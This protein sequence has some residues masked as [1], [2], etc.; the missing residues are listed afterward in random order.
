MLLYADDST[1]IYT[2]NAKRAVMAKNINEAV[3]II[4]YIAERLGLIFELIKQ[5]YFVVAYAGKMGGRMKPKEHADL[6]LDLKIGDAVLTKEYT[7][8]TYLGL[9]IDAHLDWSIHV[10][11]MVKNARR[12]YSQIFHR[13]KNSQYVTAEWMRTMLVRFVVS[14]MCYLST[15]WTRTTKEILKPVATLF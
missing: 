5:K 6:Y 1:L 2:G 11:Y 8:I 13:F 9:K 12:A 4:A 3:K 14:K 10:S 7:S 15:I